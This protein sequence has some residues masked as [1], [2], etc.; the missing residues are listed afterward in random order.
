MYHKLP[1]S[2][3]KNKF[4]TYKIQFKY[5]ALLHSTLNTRITGTRIFP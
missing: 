4:Q 5:Y 3:Y 2:S 1:N